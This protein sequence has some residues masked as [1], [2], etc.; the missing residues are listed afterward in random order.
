MAEVREGDV[1]SAIGQT[2]RLTDEVFDTGNLVNC[3]AATHCL[4]SAL[5]IR[6]NE[7]DIADAEAAI[8]RLSGALPGARRVSRDIFVLRLRAMVAQARGEEIYREFRDLYRA[9]AN[10]L[11]FEGHMAWAAAMP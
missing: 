8:E 7:F 2:R 9:M 3:D 5:L 1:D 10:D 6:G 4:V 11:G